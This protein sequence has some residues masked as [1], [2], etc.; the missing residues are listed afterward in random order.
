MG[1][2]EELKAFQNPIYPIE[3]PN[4][5][6]KLRAGNL[7]LVGWFHMA[8]GR[9]FNPFIYVGGG[10]MMYKRVTGLNVHFRDPKRLTSIH[11]PVG[12]GFETFFSKSASFAMDAGVRLLDDHTE[13]YKFKT[14]DWYGSIKAGINIYFGSGGIEDDDED[15]L[16]NSAEM[17]L[18]TDPAN[19]D[20]DGDGL[21]DGEEARRYR[22]N[23]LK[24]DS[25]GDG[26]LDG[27]EVLKFRTDPNQTDSDGDGLSDGVEI[28]KYSTDPLKLD[29]DGDTLTDGDEVLKY[30]TDPLKVDTDGDGLSDWDE[31]RSYK[32]DPLKG[33]TDGDGLTDG[34]E[35]KKY[36][37]DPIRNDTDSGGVNDGAEVMRGTN[38]LDP[39][40]DLGGAGPQNAPQ[41]ILDS[42]KSIVL[43]GVNF[44]TGSAKLLKNSERTLAR[45]LAALSA[46]PNIKVEIVGH[47]DNRGS[48]SGNQKLSLRRAESVRSWLVKRGISSSRLSARGKGMT[49]PLDT[50]D[51]A[52]G[53]ANNRRIEFRVK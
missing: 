8:P 47:T 38:P 6:L 30:G 10:V 1:G 12:V 29:T 41:M 46:N 9:S 33:D 23:P 2:Y 18:G 21:K 16:S 53:R 7:N 52:E 25:D 31:V 15:G 11:I 17:S 45:A 24:D 49:E 13:L 36:K 4:E 32:S 26:I 50:N 35:A 14:L 3:L 22:S 43:E 20:S 48:A 39:R 27:D 5:Y 42:G 44:I 51:T 28:N 34:D 40:D 19:P 37:S